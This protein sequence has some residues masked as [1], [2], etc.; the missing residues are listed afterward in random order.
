VLVVPARFAD[1]A[2]APLTQAELREQ[3]FG[4]AGGGPINRAFQLASGGAFTLRG[5]VAPWVTTSVATADLSA[6]PASG[7]LSGLDRYVIDALQKSDA[8]VDFGLFDND[9][10][11]GRPN[12]GDDDGMVDGGVA[13]VNSER[14]RYCDGGTG[15]GPHP[16]AL[17][18]WLIDGQ[19][20]QTQDLTPAGAPIT[21]GGYTL[22]GAAGCGHTASVSTLAH[23]LGHLFLGLP[24]L[25]HPIGGAGEV[26][27]TRRWV[28]GCW[29][30][31]A[32]GSW[33]CGRGPPVGAN[34]FNTFGAWTRISVGWTQPTVVDIDKDSTY[35]LHPMGRG[36]TV[37]RVPIAMNEYLLLEYR[38]AV[39]GDEQLPSEGVLMYQVADSL[40]IRPATGSDYRVSLIE[41]DDDGGL[42]R[43]ELQ[44]GDRGLGSDAFGVDRHTLAAVSHSRARSIAGGPFPFVVSEISIDRARHRAQVRIAPLAPS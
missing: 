37:L 16:F 19:R 39:A 6:P 18:N 7:L 29:E 28:I 22:L 5:E 15:K 14:N 43:S 10:P 40:P 3:M 38:E 41:A 36:G 13:I 9:G 17:L 20:Y 44:G 1:A 4:G 11:D 23:E 12:S 27:Q 33:G 2:P 8:S 31:M 42:L 30:L 21:I 34:R 25:Y 26:W 24:D 35:E 32:A